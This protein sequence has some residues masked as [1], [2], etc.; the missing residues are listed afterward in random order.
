MTRGRFSFGNDRRAAHR[1]DQGPPADPGTPAGPLD[2]PDW[3]GEPPLPAE[4]G[5]GLLAGDAGWWEPV[6]IGDPIFDFEPRPPA[7]SRQYRPDTIFDG[8]STEDFTMRLA[9]VRGYSHRYGGIT[10]Q[11]D[12]VADAHQ[13]SGTVMFAVADGVSSASQSQVGAGTA[14]NMMIEMMKFQLSK[15]HVIDL[16][17]AV[18][19]TAKQMTGEAARML[20]ETDPSPEAVEKLVATTLVAG[21]V[22][23]AAGEAAGAVVQIGDSSAW[24]LTDGRYHPL[25]DQKNDPHAQIISSAVSPLPRVPE[26]LAPVEFRLFP[27]TALLVGTDGFGDPLGDGDGKVGHLFAEH[28]RTP[29]PARGLAHLLDFSRDTF[30]DDRTLVVLWH[31]PGERGLP[32]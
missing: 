26:R 2:P 27:G 9:S 7:G 6:V 4:A 22:T 32:R 15:G 11:D 31:R 18:R 10:R 25:L 14:C 3:P 23:P 28:L 13:P 8:W 5:S 29:P 16:P 19:F 17:D 21:Y 24:I 30:D 20:R 1:R 12:A